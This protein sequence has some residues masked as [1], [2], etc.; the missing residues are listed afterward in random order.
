M[1]KILLCLLCVPA[2]LWAQGDLTKY[3]SPMVGTDNTYQ[4][5]NGNVLH[6]D[7]AVVR[8]QG[9]EYEKNYFTRVQLQRGGVIEYRLSGYPNKKR[10]LR[11]DAAPYSFTRF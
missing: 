2:L 3:V 4:F 5:S 6:K 10:G 1:R 7:S 9:V 8:V 11:L